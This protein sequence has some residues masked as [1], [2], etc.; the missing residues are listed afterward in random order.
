MA[1]VIVM[2]SPS[3]RRAALLRARTQWTG[4]KLG[5]RTRKPRARVPWAAACS[6]SL[7]VV[8]TSQAWRSGPSD[9]RIVRSSHSHHDAADI[10][11]AFHGLRSPSGKSPNALA[12]SGLP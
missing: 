7:S 3:R 5:G 4:W 1:P 11:N 10:S 12:G 2:E 9:Q 6:A 8:M